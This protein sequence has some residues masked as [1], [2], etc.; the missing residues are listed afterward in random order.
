MAIHAHKPASRRG[1]Q[2]HRVA[3]SLLTTNDAIV[4]LC[5]HSNGEVKCVAY[6]FDDCFWIGLGSDHT[7]H[8]TEAVGVSQSKP[9]AHIELSPSRTHI[10]QAI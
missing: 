4:V 7:D 6:G 9:H 10:M 5:D 2:W 8:K 1:Y 3:A